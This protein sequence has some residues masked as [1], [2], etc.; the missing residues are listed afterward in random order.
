MCAYC[1]VNSV[2]REGQQSEKF[3]KLRVKVVPLPPSSSRVLGITDIEASVWSS[4]IRTTTFGR[5]DAVGAAASATAA[6]A[7]AIPTRSRRG[8]PT[9]PN[10]RDQAKQR[11]SPR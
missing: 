2:A 3:T 4:V 8:L 11:P 7:M 1:P 6:A 9:L 10:T 5:A